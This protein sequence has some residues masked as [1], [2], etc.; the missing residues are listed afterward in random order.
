MSR[1]LLAYLALIVV[2][3]AG[4][5]L[6]LSAG[7]HLQPPTAAVAAPASSAGLTD[8]LRHNLKD[9]LSILLLQIVVIF[10]AARLVGALFARMGQPAVIG[11]MVAGILLGPSLLGLLLPGTF[12]FVFPSA[13]MDTLKLLSQVGVV[14]FMFLVGME[15]DLKHL[16]E[17]A[18]SAV[19][20]SHASILLPLLLGVALSLFLYRSY[21]PAGVAFSSFALFLGI[22]MSITAFP[23]LAR[24]LAERGLTKT[25]LG[26]ASIACAAVDD[27]S[28]WCL[29][30]VVVALVRSHGMAP[31]V[32]TIALAVAFVVVML[33]VVRPWVE[34]NL[35]PKEGRERTPAQ[36]RALL[37]GT[38]VFAF[39]SAWFTEIIGIHALF[40]AFLAG[41]AS[42]AQPEFRA[43]LR[44]RLEVLVA[45]VLLPLF[46]A[47]TG[48]RTQI[49]LLDDV[50]S[51]L[52][53]ASVVAVAIAGKLGGGMLA[54]RWTG[55]SWQDSF[56]IGALMNTR[57]LMEL[58]VLN[59]GYDLGILSQ[60]IFA[61]LV[62][63]A[64]VTTFMTAPLL[65]I[66]EA[67]KRRAAL[68]ASQLAASS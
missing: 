38:L 21:A 39:A 54:A 28:A 25:P 66:V 45:V 5:S 61:I 51:W 27:V 64:L 68:M 14:L 46:F 59:I 55:M 4:V 31:A 7:V 43:A 50:P 22:A 60:R 67:R 18:H 63:M 33:F 40:G 23:V 49:G 34:R 52:V 32:L 3:I 36:N 41:V 6:L 15:L 65:E 62:L 12:D 8:G 20:V 47:F 58:I 29:L 11:E 35:S 42:P 53:C 2:S 19:T 24:I 9:P 56:S 44:E 57:G 16:R 1:N 48:L 17:K 13:S 10:V 30:A 26:N 37:A